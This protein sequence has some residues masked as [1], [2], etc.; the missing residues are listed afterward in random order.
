[1]EKD[2]ISENTG[3]LVLTRSHTLQ[4]DKSGMNRFVLLHNKM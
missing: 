3:L 2:K 4:I 1:M